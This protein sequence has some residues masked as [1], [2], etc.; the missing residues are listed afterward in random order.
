ML[1]SKDHSTPRE[2]LFEESFGWLN[3]VWLCD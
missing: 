2:N 1:V 3:G